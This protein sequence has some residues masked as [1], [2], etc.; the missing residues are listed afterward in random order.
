MRSLN[1]PAKA[2]A[3]V[4]IR[5]GERGA[6]LALVALSLVWIVGLASLVVD[7][8]NGWVIRQRLIPATD[9]AALAAV[10]DLVDQPWNEEQACATAGTYVASNA[11]TATITECTVSSFGPDGGRLTIGAS[12]DLETLFTELATEGGAVHSVSTATWGPPLTVS[13]LRPLAFCYDGS[14]ALR[15]LIDNPPTSPTWVE[16]SFFKDDPAACGGVASVGNFATIDFE[17]GSGISEIRS[18]VLDG[19][20]GQIEFEPPTT[21]NCDGGVTCYDRPYASGYIEGQLLSLR[22]SG[23]YVAFPVFDYAD[24]DEIHLVGMIRARLYDIDI[25]GSPGDWRIELKVDP[26]LITGTCCGPPGVLSG[27]KVIAICGVDPGAYL[28]CDPES[29]S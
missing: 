21:S 12:E 16:V 26:G 13:A 27:N 3:A 4:P 1:P 7:V 22:H 28:A 9:A 8:G 10:Q 11:P 6:S 19:Y 2:T 25:D 29:A 15:Q 5:S 23:S 24:A 17:G 18:W 20:P 14:A